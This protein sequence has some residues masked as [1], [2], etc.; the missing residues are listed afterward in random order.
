M[1]CGCGE[2]ATIVCGDYLFIESGL[3]NVTLRGVQL[4][5]C[6][7]CG[8]QTP[9]LSK[10][11]ELMQVIALA[12]VLKPSSLTGKEIRFLRK[13]SGFTGEQFGKKLGLT[14]EHVSRIENQ[15]HPVGAQTDRLVRYLAVSAGSHLRKEM[16]K[17]FEQLE[18][19][20]D[21]PVHERIEINL[22]TGSFHYAAA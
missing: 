21:D 2:R 9:A 3:T 22:E 6:A 4:L 20:K 19:I 11:N 12:L 5:T 18:T 8:A 14:K 1:L 16:Q 17:L 10:I 15:H 13:Y 7:K